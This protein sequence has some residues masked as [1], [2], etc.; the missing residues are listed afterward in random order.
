MSDSKDMKENKQV[1]E[2]LHNESQSTLQEKTGD[3]IVH[4]ARHR[5][6]FLGGLQHW[7]VIALILAFYDIFAVNF[8]YFFALLLRFDFR[9]SAIPQNYYSI[10]LNFAPFYTVICILVFLKLNLYRSVWRF[11]SYSELLRVRH[12]GPHPDRR[13]TRFLWPYADFLLHR[14]HRLPVWHDPRHPLFVPFH[15]SPP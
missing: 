12:H 2:E 3:T 15:P 13:H 9:Y 11:A 5:G 1:Q 10:W 6:P 7:Q 8:S 14:G 4:S